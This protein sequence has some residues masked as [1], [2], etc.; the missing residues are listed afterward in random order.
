DGTDRNNFMV[1][2]SFGGSTNGIRIAVAEPNLSGD[3]GVGGTAPNDW[4]E[5]VSHVDPTVWHDIELRLTYH[6]GANNDVI[7]VYLDGQ[8]IGTTTTFENY[9]AALGGTHAAN[10]EANQTRRVFFRPGANGAPQDGAGGQNQGF[11]FDNLTTSVYNNLSATGNDA[12]NV[13]TGN[14]GD[15]AL[16]GLGGNDILYGND[17]NDTLT[18]GLGNDTIF[19]GAGIDTAVYSGA[20]TAANITAVSDADPLTPGNQAGWQVSAGA[21][22]IDLL[23]SVEKVSDG[24]GHHFLLV[25]HGGYATIQ[26]AVDAAANGDSIL[27]SAGTYREQVTVSG[28]HITIQGAGSGQT[29]I[30]SPAAAALTAH[31]TD[32]N[33]SRPTKYAVIT[34]VAGADV[35]ISGLTV[36]GRDQGSIPSPP[37]NYDFLGIYVLNSNAHI[38]GVTVTGIDELAG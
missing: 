34:I 14:S 31:A 27:V 4:R 16:S 32:T 5:L 13:I 9:R 25:G 22:G 30:E 6:D 12:A 20:L 3:F 29:I 37:T 35:A 11:Y 21:E 19:G 24:A 38:D 36:D 2:E 10:A 28:K 8:L 26:A 15:N 33:A 23:N 17:G 1:I 18:G 7:D